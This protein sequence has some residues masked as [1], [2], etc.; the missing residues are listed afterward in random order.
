MRFA[1]KQHTTLIYN[2]LIWNFSVGKFSVYS[3]ISVTV[4]SRNYCILLQEHLLTVKPLCF[5]VWW[6]FTLSWPA[7]YSGT[8][9][10][11]LFFCIVQRNKWFWNWKFIVWIS[12]FVAL[13]FKFKTVVIIY[14]STKLCH[15]YIISN[16]CIS[17]VWY[18]F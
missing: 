11:K 1:W 4:P 2:K 18:Y 6:W 3:F 15:I 17:A 9:C 5:P 12:N 16:I 14:F 10:C 8:V 13:G 7:L